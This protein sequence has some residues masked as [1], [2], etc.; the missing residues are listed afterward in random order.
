MWQAKWGDKTN[1]PPRYVGEHL[2]DTVLPEVLQRLDPERPYIPSSPFG[3]EDPNSGGQGDQHYWDVWHGRGDWVHYRD[4]TARFAS[5]TASPSSP[6][7][8]AWREV[9][10]PGRSFPSADVP[11]VEQADLRGG[12]RDP[13]VRWHD[14]TL[15]GYETFLGYVWLHYP[16]STKFEDWVY[17]SQ[18]NQRDAIRAAIEHYRR[19]EFC[20]GSLIWQLN[21]CWPVQSWALVDS[22][23]QPKSAWFE[24][25]RL[26]APLLVSL[27]RQGAEIAVWV[28]ADNAPGRTFSGKLEL[29]AVSLS[30][31]EVLRR[32]E[33]DVAVT[34]R[35]RKRVLDIKTDG[36]PNDAL[37]VATFAGARASTLIVEPKELVLSPP[38]TLEV[39]LF[40]DGELALSSPTALV[41]L[42]LWDDQG[43]ERFSNN[44][45]TLSQRG[46]VRVGYRGDGLGLRARS[47]AGDH[48]LRIT[49]SRL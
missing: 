8:R 33:A 41:D 15:K 45:L 43:T 36:L 31:G 26:H 3:G 16:E 32:L 12:A 25:K 40:G 11:V 29:V 22:L 39:S 35:E 30:S 6:S 19:S 1:H 37:I 28:I 17:Y 34:D 38:A 42:V 47:L 5:S 49:R 2:Y 9:F 44:A 24:L 14:K 10:R 4:S 18:L 46:V 48:P 7:L 21:D 23:G 27:D 20:K 13:I